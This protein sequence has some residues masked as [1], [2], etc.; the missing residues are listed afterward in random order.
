MNKLEHLLHKQDLSYHATWYRYLYY[1]LELKFYNLAFTIWIQGWYTEFLLKIIRKIVLGKTGAR[2][3]LKI[4]L[5]SLHKGPEL[6]P[7][8]VRRSVDIFKGAESQIN[9]KHKNNDTSSSLPWT[10]LILFWVLFVQWSI[11]SSAHL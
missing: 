3:N 7:S 4:T 1:N 6:R 11:T 8:P 9:G 10:I 5:K 2:L